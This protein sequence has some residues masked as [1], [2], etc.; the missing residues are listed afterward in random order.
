M[1]SLFKNIFLGLSILIV[2][3]SIGIAAE[4][5]DIPI[6][7]NDD[8]TVEMTNIVV[9]GID[10]KIILNFKNQEFR[11]KFEGYPV[12]IK[13]NDKP[14]VLRIVKGSGTFSY[15]FT[16]K[17]DFKITISEYTYTKTIT[18]IPLWF[19][20]I[21]PLIAILFALIFKEVFTAL[22]IG[23]LAGTATIFWYQDTAIIP[24]IF[25]G[26]FAIIDTYML[27]SL[28][29]PGH[30]SIIIFSMLIGAMVNIITRNGGMKGV[31][32]ILSNYANSPR[33]GQFVTWLLGIAIFFDDYAN[34]LVVG[35]TMRP[36]T[37]KLKISR[38]KLA[39]I[40]DSTAAP[41]TAIAFVTTWIGAE[42]SYIQ[43]GINT[44]GIT[45][46]AYGI[47]L[48]SLGYAFYP[49]FT[50]IFI[51]ILIRNQGDFG[52]MH[53]AEK[54]A[55]LA[56]DINLADDRNTFSNKLNE[57]DVPDHIIPRWY[58]AAIPVFIIIFGT[59]AG[60]LYT[61]WDQTVWNDGSIS[62]SSK[63]S[64]IIG[65]SDSY[66]ALLWSSVSGVLIAILLTLVQKILDLKTTIDSMING[67][68]TMLTAIIILILAW[69]I[70]LVTKHLHTADFISQSLVSVNISPQFI[71]AFTFILGALVA[72]STGSSWGTMAILYPLIL[73]SS[74]L[75]AQNF[76]LDHEESLAIFYNV[77]SAVLAGS[78]M[79][80]HCSPIS[81][82]TILSSLASSCNHIEHVRT[83][84]PYALTVGSVS[85]II[86]TI[87]SAFG[88]SPW[89]LF[90]TGI[91][92][93][94]LIVK[95]VAKPY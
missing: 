11:R 47:F 8:V 72:F 86:G 82:T 91:L 25:K 74:W 3:V 44:I 17:Q 51:L 29:E 15:K 10:V 39:Y 19:S 57:L 58:N 16:E 20:V 28:T 24:A 9:K 2:T 32:N 89:I 60:L 79:G 71:P 64:T 68:R 63:L 67:F 50:L 83:Q 5:P 65:N 27:E 7:N 80:D 35:N 38:E 56:N 46:S 78:V 49:I 42:L 87:P 55:R 93:M 94:F 6:L 77:V 18:P 73:P 85:I 90:P 33:S 84:L 54:K 53:K 12:T 26:M 36:V 37:D 41:I 70:A 45:E 14:V 43:D 81:D 66:K 13:V 62:F 95:F 4:T 88:V 92:V 48:S 76:G 69:S 30:M 31:V 75:I 52:P 59:F 40:V 61:G 23:I 34:T 21:P 22:F 1:I